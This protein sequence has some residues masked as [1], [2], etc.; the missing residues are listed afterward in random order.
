V[1]LPSIETFPRR[2][3]FRRDRQ[4]RRELEH[5]RWG[6]GQAGVKTRATPDSAPDWLSW[7][8]RAINSTIGEQVKAFPKLRWATQRHTLAESKTRPPLIASDLTTHWSAQAREKRF[9][10]MA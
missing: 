7:A 4:I 10:D 9:N 3:P 6:N 1:A 8:N 5:S 2:I